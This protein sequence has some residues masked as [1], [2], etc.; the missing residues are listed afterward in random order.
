MHRI[1][2][3]TNLYFQ[4]PKFEGDK[5]RSHYHTTRHL[6][7]PIANMMLL[8]SSS[9]VVPDDKKRRQNFVKQENELIM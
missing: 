7:F 8:K 2:V 3:I 9:L 5:D 4:Y 1:Q 6:N